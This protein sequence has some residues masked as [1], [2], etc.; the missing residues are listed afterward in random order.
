MTSST[1]ETDLGKILDQINQNLTDFRQEANQ[2]LADFRQETNQNLVDF[3]Q[4]A[5]QNLAD[6][7]QEANQNLADFRQ[8]TNH[9]LDNLTQDVVD[10]KV[11]Q[12][13]IEEKLEGLDKRLEN[14]EFINRSVFVGIL[15]TLGAGIIKLL[16]PDFLS[17]P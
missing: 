12:A 11:G 13:R 4:E 9:K 5:N 1:I 6:F 10:L 17:S 3:R 14:Q 15:L 8:E 2:N 7:R 16:F